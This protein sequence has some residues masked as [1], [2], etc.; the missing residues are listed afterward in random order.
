MKKLL[1]FFFLPFSLTAQ[2]VKWVQFLN[3]TGFESLEAVATDTEDNVYAGGYFDGALSLG[4]EL[5]TALGI[6]D[7]FLFKVSPDGEPLWHILLGGGGITHV[8][9]IQLDED[10]KLLVSGYFSG[11]L[12]FSGQAILSAGEYEWHAFMLWITTEGALEQ[13]AQVP[14]SNLLQARRFFQAK[15]GGYYLAGE[16]RGRLEYGGIIMQNV[17]SYPDLFILKLNSALDVVW[18]KQLQADAVSQMTDIEEGADESLFFTAYYDGQLL[19]DELALD[20]SADISTD[21]VVFKFDGSGQL[22]WHQVVSG[23]GSTQFS[24]LSV[25]PFGEIY[26]TGVF[27]QEI[28]LGAY[29]VRPDYAFNLFVCKLGA[30]G[31]PRRMFTYSYEEYN[32]GVC[33]RASPAG[34]FWLSGLYGGDFSLGNMPLDD[35]GEP[36]DGFLAKFSDDGVATSRWAHTINGP[37]D[38]YIARFA[39]HPDGPLYGTATFRSSTRIGS[40]QSNAQG[41]WA[42]A[43]FKI[44]CPVNKP[45]ITQEG[46]ILFTTENYA[47]YQWYKDGSPIPG[48]GA[49]AT[50]EGAGQYQVAVESFTGCVTIS[51]V[52]DV[53]AAAKEASRTE[54]IMVYPNPAQQQIFIA[55]WPQGREASG[56]LLSLQGKVLHHWAAG[57]VASGGPLELPVLS[58]GIYLV[59][60]AD[61][62]G[63]QFTR[64]IVR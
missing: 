19:L 41:G 49:A 34:G 14:C 42:I 24:S 13:A 30:D 33:I 23:E 45:V 15:D 22:F 32:S 61:E 18:Y 26:L 52:M 36:S 48:N 43:L 39:V 63:R 55:N 10:G 53:A 50:A 8:S 56:R 11:Q 51:D 1:L 12:F 20:A 37:D 27:A 29:F 54:E 28:S 57:E 16:F 64:L 25:D 21:G 9:D 58:P 35:T 31:A 17:D 47:A 60:L 4:G 40:F 7:G 44:D 38:D 2:N 5:Y 62:Q 3:G 59:E 46:N 6:A